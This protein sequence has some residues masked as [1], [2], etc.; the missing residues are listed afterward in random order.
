MDDSQDPRKLVTSDDPALLETLVEQASRSRD[1]D[2]VETILQNPHL[3]STLKQKAEGVFV[4]CLAKQAEQ[5]APS[6]T[7][8]ETSSPSEADEP[9][10]VSTTHQ[11]EALSIGEKIKLA[12][13]GTREERFLLVRDTNKVISATVLK[14]PKLSESEVEAIAQMRNVS[15][16]I[17][18]LISKKRQWLRNY[19]VLLNLAKNP[20]TPISVSLRLV[21]LLMNRDLAF[22]AKD[23]NVPDVLR[24]AAARTAASRSGGK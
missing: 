5:A 17:L 23:K 3:T 18:E 22:L 13:F 16:E 21:T 1:A 24:R 9:T 12:L 8:P 10:S 14:S 7:P 11:V 4:D 20:K 15:P 19:T 6:I 2:L